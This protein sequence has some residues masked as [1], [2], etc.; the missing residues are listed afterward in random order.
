L[1]YRSAKI[2]LHLAALFP[3]PVPLSK[4]TAM[5]PEF[6]ELIS[7]LKV[8]DA[9]FCQLFD[10]HD[11]LDEQIHN[12]ESGVIPADHMTIEALKKEKL[13]LKDMVYAVLKKADSP[14]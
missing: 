7:R 13:Q 10:R 4:E 5:F 9:H 3:S 2:S 6:H 12:M 1:P 14:G 11:E 8:E